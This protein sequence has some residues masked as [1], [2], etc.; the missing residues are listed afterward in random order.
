MDKSVDQLIHSLNDVIDSGQPLNVTEYFT[1]FS[2]YFMLNVVFDIEVGELSKFK[3]PIITSYKK[4]IHKKITLSQSI[5]FV[6]P[7]LT[8]I[9][10]LY[11]LSYKSIG[12][13]REIL[14]NAIKTRDYKKETE[15]RTEINFIDILLSFESEFGDKDSSEWTQPSLPIHQLITHLITTY[16]DHKTGLTSQEIK[17]NLIALFIAA[18]ESIA[19]TL[20]YCIYFLANNTDIQEKAF[21]EVCDK[22][23]IQENIN[24]ESLRELSYMEAFIKE[25]LRF[26][27]PFPRFERIV[28]KDFHLET[29]EFGKIFLPKDSIVSVL[30]SAVHMDGQYFKDPDVFNPNRF[31]PEYQH[32][33]NPMAFIPFANGPRNCIGQFN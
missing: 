16:S 21:N 20:S 18:T 9:L 6:H 8:R 32:L 12:K 10:N 1:S 2:L 30:A 26:T 33:M 13:L 15:I 23:K 31:L 17:D 19:K 24:W 11:F 29:E 27:T 28:K 4:F 7:V 5:C 22:I 14:E 25:V 3:H